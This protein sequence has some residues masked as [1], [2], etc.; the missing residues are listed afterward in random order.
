M[1]VPYEKIRNHPQDFNV[2]YHFYLP[3]EGGRKKIPYQGYRCDFAYEEY[4][5]EDKSIYAIHPEFEDELGNIILVDDK[6]VRASGTARMWIL[7]QEMREKVHRNRIKVGTKGYFME[8]SRRVGEV[9]VIEIIG[10]HTNK[11]KL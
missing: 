7:F 2:K 8:G 5:V 6:P 9:E 3:Q 1:W 11:E 10:L 4:Y